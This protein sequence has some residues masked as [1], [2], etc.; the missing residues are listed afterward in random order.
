MLAQERAR[1]QELEQ[2]LAARADEQRLLAQERARTQELEQQLAARA[3]EQKLL[4]QERARTQE[5]EQQLVAR[6]D[7]QKLLAQERARTQE[8]EQ[9]LAARQNDQKLVAQERARSQELEQQLAARADERKLLAQERARNQE[10]E[11]QLAARADEQ[12]LLAQERVRTQE[13]EKQL[14]IRRSGRKLVAPETSDNLEA[15][16]RPAEAPLPSAP[17]PLWQYK[18]KILVMSGVLLLLFAGAA[19]YAVFSSHSPDTV[20]SQTAAKAVAPPA[21]SIAPVAV[22][23]AKVGARAAEEA[24]RRDASAQRQ[25]EEQRLADAAAAK[26]A[27]EEARLSAEPREADLGM[28]YSDRQKLQVALSS[29]G[30][31][32]GGIDGRFGPRTRQMIWAWQI[33]IGDISTGFFTAAQKKALLSEGAPAI[34]K[35]EDE[36]RRT[37]D[38]KQR[39]AIGVQ[40]LPPPDWSGTLVAGQRVLRD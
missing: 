27:E 12:I 14:S 19:G 8:L 6:A 4:A 5:L 35:W 26:A 21:R 36:Q 20:A 17:G 9:Q 13:L 29:L 25:A 1:T 31:D 2:Q 18:S 34:A 7:E 24:N 37:S 3:D 30:F 38:E 40:Y 16:P 33:K 23:P 15:E 22:D 10:L 28:T 11:Q 32:V 39:R